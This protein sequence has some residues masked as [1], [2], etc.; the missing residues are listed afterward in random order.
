MTPRNRETLFKKNHAKV[1]LGIAA[2]DLEAAKVVLESQ[3]G[4]KEIAAFLAQQSI[5]KSIKA[6]LIS[7][8]I[9]VPMVHDAGV[10]VAKLP[11]QFTPPRGYD[12]SELTT[13]AT[14]LRYREGDSALSH[15]DAKAIVEIA[16]SVLNW[17]K[18]L[19]T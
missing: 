6:V 15:D 12:L 8:E 19:V 11:N 16:A 13:Y 3:V 4:R 18:T 17:A 9:P 1:L 10:L 14:V 7:L 2:A 5:E